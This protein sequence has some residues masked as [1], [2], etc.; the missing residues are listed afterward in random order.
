MSITA[1][2]CAAGSPP[3]SKRNDSHQ[4][5]CEID[6]VVAE[7][8]EADQSIGA[9]EKVFGQA[10]TTVAPTGLVPQLV[11][12]KAHQRCFRAGEEGG[13][14][15]E[16]EKQTDEACKGTSSPKEGHL[17]NVKNASVQQWPG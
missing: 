2:Q 10:C 7:Q 11:T 14:Q 3:I 1:A 4:R 17:A 6:E 16:Q 8:Y 5:G 13:K 9:L 15:Q 12:V